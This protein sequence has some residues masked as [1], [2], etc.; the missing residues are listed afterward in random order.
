MIRTSVWQVCA[1]GAAAALVVVV[2]S[3]ATNLDLG[4]PSENVMPDAETTPTFVAEDAGDAAIDAETE[5]L[6]I[7]TECP[8]PYSTCGV[9]KYRCRTNLS[10]D[11]NNCGACGVQCPTY[12][13]LNITS[14]CVAGKCEFSCLPA[15]G[16]IQDCNGIIDDGCETDITR[17]RFN[18]GVCGTVCAAGT[19]CHE[20]KCGCPPGQVE[21]NGECVD[22]QNDDK[23]C[24][25]CG[26]ACD[27][28]E[29]VCGVDIQYAHFGCREGQCGRLKCSYREVT[30]CN[31][32]LGLGCASNGCE[33]IIGLD[34]A[35]NCGACGNA[36]KPGGYCESGTCVDPPPPVP[37]SCPEGLV[38]CGSAC[39]DPLND[40]RTCGG[41]DSPCASGPHQIGSCRKGIC[42]FECE[43]GWGDCT[44]ES[45]CETNLNSHPAHCG[46]CG[47]HCETSAG[48]P[49][50]EGKCLM[51]ECDAGGT[52]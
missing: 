43:P 52:K 13:G 30:D 17:D 10:S 23:N 47:N 20:G 24:G 26:A 11:E 41:C 2:P 5:K 32:D 49:C 22:T 25:A 29:N 18:C 3:C 6:C 15:G 12:M 14:R 16:P 1:F 7:A 28:T 19:N 44:D 33:T 50:I 46:A 21:C 31:K 51:T 40:V 8:F 39:F 38:L 4:A 48:Q 42:H 45:G 36:C 27:T 34:D 9:D 37:T 35:Q